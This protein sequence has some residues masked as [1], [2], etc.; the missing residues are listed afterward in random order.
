MTTNAPDQRLSRSSGQDIFGIDA[1]GYHA[2]RIGYPDAMYEALWT[3]CNGQPDI[4]EVGAGTGL[5]TEAILDR[6]PRSL[7]VV[8]PSANLVAFMAERLHASQLRF[9]VAGFLEADVA[10]P[11][12]LAVCAAAFH[13]LE[14]QPALAR[15]R[16][17]LR[18][19]GVWA[20]WW[21][22][23][24]NAGIGD[25]LSDAVMPLLDGMAMPPSE[26]RDSHYSLDRA[27]HERTLADAGFDRVECHQYRRERQ[28]RT[29][30]VLALYQSYSYIRMLPTEQRQQFLARLEA[31]V[32]RDFGGL[33]PNIVLTTCYSARSPA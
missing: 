15:V 29:D 20:M 13:W 4:L 1:A 33:A 10:G 9:V 25:P 22:S 5:A 32:E 8:E 31:S 27:L 7:T 21:N 6:L 11:F 12:D 3:R 2:G 30:Q 26:G 18:L 23:Y 14:P 28:L 24:R 17:L 19:D 16:R